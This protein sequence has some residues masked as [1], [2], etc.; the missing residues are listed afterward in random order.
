LGADNR[1]NE[2]ATAP[3][4]G[5]GADPLVDA[6][7]VLL[8]ALPVKCGEFHDNYRDD[9]SVLRAPKVVWFITFV[10]VTR[11]YSRALLL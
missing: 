6:L 11:P 2:L 1:T 10:A 7:S 3:I 5:V 8:T 4:D 9:R